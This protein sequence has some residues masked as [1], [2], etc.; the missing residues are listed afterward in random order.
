MSL[1]AVLFTLGCSDALFY[2]FVDDDKDGDGI[3]D[4]KDNCLNTANP[5][6]KDTDG[7]SIG[8]ACDDKNDNGED[9]DEVV[10]LNLSVDPSVNGTITSIPE[11]IDCGSEG[12][13]CSAS[14][15][16]GTIVTLT[17]TADKDYAPGAWQGNCAKTDS[18]EVCRLS[19]DTNKTVSKIFSLLDSDGDG[20][21]DATDV[22]D[23]NDGL[24]EVHNLNMFDHIRHNLAGTSY[25]DSGS[26]ADNQTGAPTDVTDD[27]NTATTGAY[28]CGYELMRDLDFANKGSYGAGTVNNAW[29]PLDASSNVVGADSAVNEGFIG[30]SNFA[31]I[32][33]GNGHSTS[34][35]YSRGNG[36]RG[37]FR[38]TTATA[39]IRNVG[40]V[41]ARLYGGAGAG[42]VGGL[43][44]W[45]NS[46]SISVSYAMGAVHGGAG[47]DYVGGLVGHISGGSISASYAT[48]AVHGG[49]GTDNVGGLVGYIS[50]GSISASYT[51]GAVDG[52]A[53]NYDNVGGLVGYNAGGNIGASFATGAVD[54]GA[55]ADT[56]G[57]LVGWNNGSIGASYATGDANG[58]DMND[59]VGSLVGR[60]GGSGNIMTSHA[61]SVAHGGA[62]D[63]Y[64]GGLVGWNDSGGIT[65]SY[66]MGVVYGDTGNDNVGG[67]VGWNNNGDITASFATG[68]AHGNDGEDNVGGLVGLNADKIR[69]S[70]ATGNVNGGPKNDIIGGLVGRNTAS[71]VASYYAIGKADGG[72]GDDIVGSL[73]GHRVRSDSI[74]ASYSF[75]GT[76][77]VG[78]S[79]YDG[80]TPPTGVITANDL[81]P[82]NAGTE[83]DQT[84]SNTKD[85]WDF[86]NNSQAPA[87]RYADYDGTAG[88]DYDCDQFMGRVLGIDTEL[89]CNITLLPNQPGR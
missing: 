60:N 43:V 75:G 87:L 85:A 76:D 88:T 33:E 22:D 38:S 46:G 67:L 82:S 21:P 36:N 53:G 68:A 79:G 73:V 39:S 34:H 58:G 27:C 2:A 18:D 28:L 26:A 15:D 78:T 19:M 41:A 81:T 55:G 72:G 64:V 1:T 47:D 77:N 66:G 61:T 74:T 13:D 30:P 11:G 16:Y 63:D 3:Y 12:E 6:Q 35:L 37:L 32:F 71:I 69:A 45:N 84:A 51:T 49:A 10:K 70:Y 50:G 17:A 42:T 57:G 54:G 89:K 56:V 25:K 24:I 44:G 8:D 31:G 83:W 7:D 4:L 29:R 5:E 14:F 52:G 80:D 65:A 62:G 40:V 9:N 59:Y 86:G 20:E 23:D 48:G